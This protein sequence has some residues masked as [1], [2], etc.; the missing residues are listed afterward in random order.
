VAVAVP[1]G[2]PREKVGRVP[3]EIRCE[4]REE[5]KYCDNLLGALSFFSA[6]F[7]LLFAAAPRLLK[8][9][10]P[11]KVL[12]EKLKQCEMK[13]RTLTCASSRGWLVPC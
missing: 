9:P 5:K 8:S 13:E 3:E 4:S 2:C 1:V 10:P 11:A 12:R 7:P 6:D